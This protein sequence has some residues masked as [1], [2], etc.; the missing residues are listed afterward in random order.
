MLSKRVLGKIK[1]NHA[2][3]IIGLFM[4]DVSWTYFNARKYMRLF[5]K[6]D[7]IGIEMNPI[8]KYCWRKF[9]LNMGT[10]LGGF[11]LFI[12]LLYYINNIMNYEIYY[13]TLGAY[14]IV[15][16][17]HFGMWRFL[18]NAKRNKRN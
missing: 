7:Y 2:M 14:T 5:P 11:A 17:L 1:M 9:G 13:F 18:K 15:I 4:I 10:L 12:L 16:F 8:V 3:L 6:N